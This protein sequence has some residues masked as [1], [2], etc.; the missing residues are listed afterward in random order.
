MKSVIRKLELEICGDHYETSHTESKSGYVDERIPF[1]PC[2]VPPSRF[3]IV[4]KHIYSLFYGLL[5]VLMSKK[6]ARLSSGMDK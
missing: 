3:D 2:Y 5:S 6:Y 4:V 1:V